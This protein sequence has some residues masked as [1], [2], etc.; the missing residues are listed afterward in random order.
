MGKSLMEIFPSKM[1]IIR[2]LSV[3]KQGTVKIEQNTIKISCTN[4]YK[5]S[6]IKAKNTISDQKKLPADCDFTSFIFHHI[7]PNRHKY[8]F[9][10]CI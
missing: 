9:G 6:R 4:F 5:P 8:S 7:K 10:A 2:K 3:Y 1:G